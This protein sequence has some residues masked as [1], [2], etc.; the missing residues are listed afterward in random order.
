MA[1]VATI[2]ADITTLH[3]DAIVN[4]ANSRLIP[5]GGVDGAIHAAAGPE[6]AVECSKLGDCLPGEV[7]LTSAYKL[8]AKHVIHTV[9]PI[10]G[11][12]RGAESEI[13]YSC[14][15]ESLRLADENSLKTI[16]FPQI[17]T[18]AYGFPIDEARKVA[19]NA[20]SD[21]FENVP[22]SAIKTVYLVRLRAI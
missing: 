19:S 10:Y 20:I 4:A 9:G 8:P 2:N 6:L 18:G 14:Y 3:V 11:Q 15:Y 5:G 22:D 13:L 16:A 21:Y 17:S 1:E 7:K 12:H